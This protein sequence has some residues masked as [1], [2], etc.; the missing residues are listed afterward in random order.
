VPLVFLAG[1][2]HDN[3]QHAA[4]EDIRLQNLWD[5]IETDAALFAEIGKAWK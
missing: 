1:A 3:H 2:N 5:M 4:N